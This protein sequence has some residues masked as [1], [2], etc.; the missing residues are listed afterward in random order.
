MNT[1]CL[2]CCL[3]RLLLLLQLRAST[4]RNEHAVPGWV[5]DCDGR[6]CCCFWFLGVSLCHCAISL[7]AHSPVCAVGLWQ[8][9][10]A[11]C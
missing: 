1:L 5:M 7:A 10:A 9:V 4:S 6:F 2:V 8:Q 3:R 11:V